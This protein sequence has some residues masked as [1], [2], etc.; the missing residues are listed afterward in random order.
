MYE[1]VELQD[2]PPIAAD[3]I[4]TSVSCY[5]EEDGSA[6]VNL[7]GGSGDYSLTWDGINP[8]ALEE[9]TYSF[10][11]T[12]SNGC[13]HQE[14]VTITE[15]DELEYRVISVTDET[16]AGAEDATAEIEVTGGTHLITLHGPTVT[17]AWWVKIYQQE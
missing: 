9:G 8:L 12:D 16:M 13:Q 17:M 1:G 15:P 4:I 7:S 6:I 3:V 10:T 2:F 14:S 11:A 5:G